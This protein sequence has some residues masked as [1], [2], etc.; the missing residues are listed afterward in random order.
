MFV[1]FFLSF[2]F[3]CFIICLMTRFFYN[4]I[5]YSSMPASIVP[6]KLKFEQAYFLSSTFILECSFVCFLSRE[7]SDTPNSVI[8]KGKGK[9]VRDETPEKNIEWSDSEKDG[10]DVKRASVFFFFYSSMGVFLYFG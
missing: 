9:H 5:L 8:P 1:V 3:L 4:I 6:K 2:V 7:V 10:K